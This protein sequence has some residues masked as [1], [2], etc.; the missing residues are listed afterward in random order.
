[1][2]LFGSETGLALGLAVLA[3]ETVLPAVLAVRTFRRRDW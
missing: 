1:M 3:L 2:R